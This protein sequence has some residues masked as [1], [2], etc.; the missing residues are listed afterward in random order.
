MKIEKECLDCIYNQSTRVSDFL[1]VTPTQA[2][3]IS[4]IAKQHIKNFDHSSTPPHNATPMYE[5]IAKYLNVDDI[6]ADMKDEASQSAQKFVH[7]CKENISKSNDAL[8]GAIKTAIAGNVID[9]AAEVMFDLDD[10]IKNI[11]KTPFAIDDFE[12]LKEKLTQTKTL[13]YL[14]DNAGEEVFDKL[15]IETIKTIFPSIKVYYFVRGKAIINDLTVEHANKSGLQEVAKIVN[16]GVPTPGYAIDLADKKA[17]EIFKS[18]DCII[19]KGMGNYECLGEE[20]DFPIY[21]LL[22]VKCQ[23]VARAIGANLG[24]IVCK[25]L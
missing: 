14:A 9:L 7:T 20:K 13:V 16:S 22:K 5:D 21:F 10:E 3:Y 4:Q 2:K 18:A 11:F 25:K 19:S 23:V 6:Y 24:D 15:C 12:S 8:E 1:K 17:H